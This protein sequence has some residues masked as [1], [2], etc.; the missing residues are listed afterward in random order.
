[1][2][3]SGALDLGDRVCIPDKELFGFVRYVGEVEGT[4]G[5][6][7]GVELDEPYG[8]NDGSV[9]GKYYFR[10]KPK[11]GVFA[12]QHQMF[13]TISGN[14]LREQE[15]RQHKIDESLPDDNIAAA[16]QQ[17]ADAAESTLD[18]T[19]DAVAA[20]DEATAHLDAQEEASKLSLVLLKASATHRRYLMTL[21]QGVRSELVEHERF[22]NYAST[23]SSADAVQYLQQLQNCA[24]EKIVLSDM[25]IQQII[26]AQQ[27]ARES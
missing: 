13:L 20:E 7:I 4:K 5:V 17:E 16:E 9:K 26:Q 27:A 3:Q 22:A 23:A 10:C 12:R 6:W 2:D 1:M 8:K 21:L 15:A 25:F 24:Q 18:Q 19:K 11:H 14:K